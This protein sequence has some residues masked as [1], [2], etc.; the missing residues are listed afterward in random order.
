MNGAERS[1]V[2][3]V[4]M[5]PGRRLGVP[6]KPVGFVGWGTPGHAYSCNTHARSADPGSPRNRRFRGVGDGPGKGAPRS[7]D[8]TG[9]IRGP[10]EACFVGWISVR[11]PATLLQQPPGAASRPT[12]GEWGP[13]RNRRSSI[14]LWPGVIRVLVADDQAAVREGVRYLLEQQADIAV[15]GEV[16][17][18]EEAVRLAAELKPDVVIIEPQMAGG[19]GGPAVR[20]IMRQVP[21]PG[22]IVLSAHTDDD[23]LVAARA[24][25]LS[26]LA[27]DAEPEELLQGV[28]AAAQ[29]VNLLD[30]RFAEASEHTRP[31]HEHLTARELDVLTRI[32]HGQ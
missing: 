27:K 18:G 13:I 12:A 26:Y 11:D 4:R 28:R 23:V 9:R 8:A 24:G 22:V 2:Q 17:D 5:R 15:V 16:I 30:A 20:Q 6:T 32:A 31:R 21:P 3:V 7:G 25:A 14:H 29:G 10:R 1:G 19:G